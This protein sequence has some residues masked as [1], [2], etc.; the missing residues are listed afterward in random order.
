LKSALGQ[1]TD[2]LDRLTDHVL[3][4]HDLRRADAQ[5]INDQPRRMCGEDRASDRTYGQPRLQHG[6]PSEE[7]RVAKRRL[8]ICWK[9]SSQ[10]L[11]IRPDKTPKATRSRSDGL[12]SALHQDEWCSPPM[13]SHSVP[14]S[15]DGTI[16]QK[17]WNGLRRARR[18][19]AQRHH[20]VL[21]GNGTRP[22]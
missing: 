8:A 17:Y 15:H 10:R 13:Q 7:R 1:Y 4:R 5:T 21:H 3:T 16:E 14:E 2:A 22:A 6:G 11:K 12:K 20:V 19:S 9:R 18:G